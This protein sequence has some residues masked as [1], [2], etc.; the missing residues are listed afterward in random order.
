M[1]RVSDEKTRAI[2]FTK[3]ETE[4]IIDNCL[5]ELNG[6]KQRRCADLNI[7]NFKSLFE[8]DFDIPHKRYHTII[9]I[10]EKLK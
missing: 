6:L 9:N 2:Q 3:D 5:G 8:E 1:E 10:L 7:K 4:Y